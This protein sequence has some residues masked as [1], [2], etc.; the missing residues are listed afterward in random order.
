MNIVEENV[1]KDRESELKSDISSLSTPP[2]KRDIRSNFHF[3][4]ALQSFLQIAKETLIAFAE[5]LAKFA[6]G[7]SSSRWL[8][9][10]KPLSGS[11]S[12]SKAEVERLLK[13]QKDLKD[14]EKIVGASIA[15]RSEENDFHADPVE[16]ERFIHRILQENPPWLFLGRVLSGGAQGGSLVSQEHLNRVQE[17]CE[18]QDVHLFTPDDSW[19]DSPLASLTMRPARLYSEMNQAR[20]LDQILPPTVQIERFS[21]GEIMIPVRNRQRRRLEFCRIE[22]TMVIISQKIVPILID[23]EG[24]SGSGGQLLYVLLDYSASMRGKNATLALAVISAVLRANMGQRDTRYLY[25]R[26]AEED[27]MVPHET[28]PPVI[29]STLLEKDELFNTICAVNFN[30]GATHLSNALG[31]AIQDVENLRKTEKLEAGIL[32]VTD[33]CAEVLE[34][35]ALRLRASRIQLHTIMVAPEPNPGLAEISE[36]YTR[37]DAAIGK[38]KT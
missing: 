21:R 38:T 27:R 10:I 4:S 13:R 26:F 34:N 36:T 25:R 20:L 30:G 17:V 22:R 32:L 11:G 35:T 23:M 19:R 2:Q 31:V 1:K 6:W 12:L 14:V 24:G 5:F 28:Q 15:F 33:G 18:I 37:L 29:A 16:I 8:F 9:S 3:Q 7:R